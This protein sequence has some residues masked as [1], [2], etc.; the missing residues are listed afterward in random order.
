M[1]CE[2]IVF[3][4]GCTRTAQQNY[5][6]LIASSN[7][8]F[9]YLS[10]H[11][12]SVLADQTLRRLSADSVSRARPSPKDVSAAKPNGEHVTSRFCS[13]APRQRRPDQEEPCSIITKSFFEGVTPS[14]LQTDGYRCFARVPLGAPREGFKKGQSRAEAVR[15]YLP[16]K[17]NKETSSNISHDLIHDSPFPKLRAIANNLSTLATTPLPLFAGGVRGP[18]TPRDSAAALTQSRFASLP[19]YPAHPSPRVA[20][21]HR[22]PG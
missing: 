11:R 15:Q 12:R 5:Y 4:L 22:D 1:D 2:A 6:Q 7:E 9:V 3:T 18:Q 20:R 21:L 19:K 16:I 17:N 8:A 13:I 14:I 10:V